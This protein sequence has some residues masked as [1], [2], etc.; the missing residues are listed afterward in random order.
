HVAFLSIAEV[1]DALVV[2]ELDLEAGAGPDAPFFFL[3]AL[4]EAVNVAAAGTPVAGGG[5]LQS[6]GAAFHRDDV[7]HATLAIAAFADDDGAK[8]IL[9]GCRDDLAGAGAVAIDQNGDGVAR[10]RRMV[11][12]H[13]GVVY[14]LPP[15]AALG[16]D[17]AFA[18]GQEQ[19]ADL[20]GGAQQ[21]TRVVTHVQHQAAHAQLL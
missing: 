20:N 6:T 13:A 14:F 18:L 1:G 17:H 2:G 19:R 21:A 16:C 5:E 7:L 9:Q 4:G 15:V 8:M 11:V 12:D 10:A 3:F